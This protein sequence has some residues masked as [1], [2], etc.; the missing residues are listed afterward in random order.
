MTSCHVMVAGVDSSS[1]PCCGIACGSTYRQ[2]G[3]SG[4]AAEIGGRDRELPYTAFPSLRVGLW[5]VVGDGC[6]TFRAQL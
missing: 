1:G 5:R 2:F 6:V 3:A 4:E